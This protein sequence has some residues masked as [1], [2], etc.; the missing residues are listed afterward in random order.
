MSKVK[1]KVEE[2]AVPAAIT[3]PQIDPVVKVVAINT[4][5]VGL[6][7]S[8][9]YLQLNVSKLNFG[10]RTFMIVPIVATFLDWAVNVLESKIVD[11]E[12]E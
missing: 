9:Q 5:L 10:Q 1:V 7:A 4:A 2:N 6:V 11:I 8:F 12:E 3:L